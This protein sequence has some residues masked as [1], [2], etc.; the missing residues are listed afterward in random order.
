MTTD[1]RAELLRRAG[2]DPIV[3]DR[4]PLSVIMGDSFPYDKW[5]KQQRIIT[6]AGYHTWE[7]L[8]RARHNAKNS[9]GST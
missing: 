2:K 3:L 6:R 8:L 9:T 1:R 5:E 4:R 7:D